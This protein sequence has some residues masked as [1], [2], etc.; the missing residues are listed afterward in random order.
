MESREDPDAPG[1]AQHE[2][3]MS[4]GTGRDPIGG[5]QTP[6][7]FCKMWVLFALWVRGQLPGNQ[8]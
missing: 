5:G 4:P 8:W 1:L 6:L 3:C 7:V 2:G